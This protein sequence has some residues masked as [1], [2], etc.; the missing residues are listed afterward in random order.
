MMLTRRATRQP[1]RIGAAMKPLVRTATPA[2]AEAACAVI[3][4]SIAECCIED[5]H[6]DS[7]I[8]AAWFANKTPDGLRAW[9]S[10]TDSFGVV[11]ERDG[12]LWDLRC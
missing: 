6:E 12:S 9:I 5:R 8:L 7:A 10:S 4:R 1:D 11:A 3:R 2:D